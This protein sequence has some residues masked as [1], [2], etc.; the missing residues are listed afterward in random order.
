MYQSQYGRQDRLAR[1]K[2]DDVY[3]QR[4]KWSEPTICSQ[5]RSVYT[6]G[7][8]TW[9][10]TIPDSAHKAVCPACRR[11]NDDYPA[12]IIEMSGSFFDQ[13]KEE[14]LNLIR[15]E[16]SME[17]EEHPLERIIKII[18]EDEGTTVTTT[19]VHVARRLGHAVN[20]AYKGEYEAQYLE[21]D[22]RIRISWQR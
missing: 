6:Q 17:K 3:F 19:G 9:N 12:G 2:R 22:Q 1:Q 7:R 13:H 18:E 10:K 20:S 14:I 5:C 21:D 16:E 15:H 4:E 8:W 11:I